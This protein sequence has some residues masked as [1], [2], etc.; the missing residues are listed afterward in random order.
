MQRVAFDRNAFLLAPV[1]TALREPL[2]LER[3]SR[4]LFGASRQRRA[5]EHEHKQELHEKSPLEEKALELIRRACQTSVS[6]RK[7]LDGKSPETS[8]GTGPDAVPVRL[9]EV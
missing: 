6:L 7:C 1:L 3:R 8:Q 9:R 4:G 5:K 2:P